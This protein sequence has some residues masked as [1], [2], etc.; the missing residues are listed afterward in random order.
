MNSSTQFFRRLTVS[1]VGSCAALLATPLLA[2]TTATTDPV[3]FITLS[4]AGTGGTVP[5][6]L[7]FT[8]LGLTR[9]V[10]YQGS[11]E[12]VGTSSLT[13]NDA[14][15]VDN[16]F[17]GPAGAYFVELTSGPGAGTT[18]DIATTTASTKTITTV[19]NLAAG[20]AAGVTFKIRKH[21]TI[22]SVFGPA[23]ESGLGGGNTTSADNILLWNGSGYDVFYYQTSG[24]G[25]VGWRKTGAPAVDASAKVI[26]PE[27]APIIKRLQSAAV[28]VV[29]M[30]SVKTGQ[31]SV[32]V[33]NGTNFIGNIYGAPM[34]LADCGIYTGNNSTGLAGGSSSGADQILIWNGSGYDT[35]Y[36]QTSGLGGTGWRKSGAPAVDAS[37]TQIGVGQSIIV[38]RKL[39]GSPF[40]W[41]IPQ[42]PAVL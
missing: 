10:E 24:L 1:V 39:L 27:D 17:N 26:Y 25:G 36:Y 5:S 19:Q 23:D 4:I 15:W 14:V 40:N 41:I 12:A 11:A 16:Q 6:Q 8:G 34:T 22:A 37:A 21:W 35:Y 33:V 2:Q 29:L 20:A 7:S 38:N 18:Y 30:G 31:T 9:T 3:G 32:P 28:N 42:H 13:D